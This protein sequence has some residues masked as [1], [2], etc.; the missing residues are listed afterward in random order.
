MQGLQHSNALAVLNGDMHTFTQSFE[1]SQ[2]LLHTGRIVRN[3]EA[4]AFLHNH[5]QMV[6]PEVLIRFG[7]IIHHIECLAKLG[8]EL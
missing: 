4:D 6:F 2:R 7:I 1:Y 8:K 5:L 3:I